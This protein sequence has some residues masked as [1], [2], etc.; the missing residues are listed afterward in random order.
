M[1]AGWR[2]PAGGGRAGEGVLQLG[3]PP[4]ATVCTPQSSLSEPRGSWLSGFQAPAW[5]APLQLRRVPA[6]S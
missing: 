2:L 3:E 1:S 4:P 6:H 5:K